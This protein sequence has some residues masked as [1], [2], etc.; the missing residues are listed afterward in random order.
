MLE[1]LVTGC[2]AQRAPEELARIEGVRWVVGNSHKTQIADWFHTRAK[3]TTARSL[4][5]ISRRKRILWR[6]Q[7]ATFATTAPGPN[8]KVQDGCSNRCS[9]CIIPSVRGRSRSAPLESVVAQVRD[10]AGRYCEVVLSGINLG[11]WG[12]DLPGGLRFVD[13]LEAILKR[14]RRAA[15][16]HQFSGTDGLEPGVAGTGFAA[17]RASPSIFICRCNPG[18]M[19]Y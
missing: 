11:R 1:I 8:L 9:F 12:R 4:L 3:I 6:R 15:L 7:F 10:L 18:P 17:S 5:A 2:Y 19:R 16:A 14:N 13:L